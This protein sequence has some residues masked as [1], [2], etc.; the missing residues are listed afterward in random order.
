VRSI[1]ARVNSEIPDSDR[2][3]AV[4][5]SNFTGILLKI[6]LKDE[7]MD[8]GGQTESLIVRRTLRAVLLANTW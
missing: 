3:A 2:L 4:L 6:G 1:H 5:Q 8:R 7:Q